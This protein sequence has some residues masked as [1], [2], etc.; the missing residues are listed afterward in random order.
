MQPTA[1]GRTATFYFMKQFS[2]L[3]TFAPA[4][5]GSAYSR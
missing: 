3:G 1:G 2:M 5:G 4:S